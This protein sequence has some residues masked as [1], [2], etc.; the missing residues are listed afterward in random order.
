VLFFDRWDAKRHAW[1]EG[2]TIPSLD[3]AVEKFRTKVFAISEDRRTTV[4]TVRADWFDPQLAANW[5][6]GFVALANDRM[7]TDAIQKSRRSIEFLEQE[8]AKT[9]AVELKQAIYRLIESQI[10]TAMYANLQREYAFRT[11]DPAVAS[12]P[13]RKVSPHRALMTLE[14]AFAGS[15]LAMSWVLWRRKRE[16]LL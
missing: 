14:G 4:V 11:I 13:R 7:R 8:A 2:A 1:Q 12:D 15:V 6:N 10:N 16:W 5:A 9:D 3:D